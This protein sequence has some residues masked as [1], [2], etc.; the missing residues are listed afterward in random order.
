[1][2]FATHQYDSEICILEPLQCCQAGC[3]SLGQPQPRW[4]PAGRTGRDAGG[5]PLSSCESPPPH[6][7]G[8][9]ALAAAQGQLQDGGGMVQ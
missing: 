9:A 7:V 5:L 1:M 6:S 2:V 3:V 4:S 8:A